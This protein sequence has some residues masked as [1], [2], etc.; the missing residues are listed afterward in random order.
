MD[1]DEIIEYIHLPSTSGRQTNYNHKNK[2]SR[3]I[4]DDEDASEDDLA[5]KDKEMNFEKIN[6]NET[7]NSTKTKLNERDFI[8][9]KYKVTKRNI[10]YIGQISKVNTPLLQ[11]NFLR[12]KKMF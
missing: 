12:R 11:V 2:K 9:V 8:I 4:R 10:L 7:I 3:L 6:E 5:T 1:G